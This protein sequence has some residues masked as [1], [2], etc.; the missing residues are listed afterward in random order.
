MDTRYYLNRKCIDSNL[1]YSVL[2]FITGL[3]GLLPAMARAC[4]ST[5]INESP[6][7]TA[8]HAAPANVMFVFDDS[9]SMD[10]EFMTPEDE[11]Y[12]HETP[13]DS[14]ERYYYLFPA[15]DY[16]PHTDH[17]YSDSYT[18][19]ASQRKRWKY[20]WSQYNKLYYDPRQEYHPWPGANDANTTWPKAHPFTENPNPKRSNREGARFNLA[21][22][23]LDLSGFWVR[24]NAKANTNHKYVADALR[25]KQGNNIIVTID[26][27]NSN[28]D[29]AKGYF[30]LSD[31]NDWEL[32][33][34][35]SCAHQGSYYA[36]YLKSHRSWAKWSFAIPADGDYK[37]EV[38]Y[39]CTKSWRSRN[40]TYT[41]KHA[42][43]ETDVSH[44]DNNSTKA[45]ISHNSADGQGGDWQSLGTFHFS[46]CDLSM[47]ITIYNAHYFAW[48]DSNGNGSVD[49]LEVYLVNFED[50]DGDGILDLRKYYQFDDKNGNDIV[51]C[52]SELKPVPDIPSDIKAVKR[53]ANGNST[54]MTFQEEL[55]NFANWF[56]YYRRRSLTGKAAVSMAIDKLENVNVGLYP[57]NVAHIYTENSPSKQSAVPIDTN[58][59]AILNKLYSITAY[60]TTPLRLAFQNVGKYFDADDGD[61]GGIGSAPWAS[62]ADG[63]GCQQSFSI[64]MTDGYWNGP[65]VSIGN[66]DGGDG[67]P[68]ADTYS[69][70][71]ADLA[72]YY[73][74]NDLSAA[75]PDEVPVNDCDNNTK[76]HMVTYG[77][78]FGVEGELSPSYDAY[79]ECMLDVINRSSN[80]S[81]APVWP[82]PHSC[83]NCGKKVDDLWHAAVNGRGTFMSAGNPRE[84]FDAL[85]SIVSNISG[86]S[87]SGAAVSINSEKL[88]TD[89]VLFQ[90]TYESGSWTGDLKAFTL[91]S[92]TGD[93]SGNATWS[94]KI[95]LADQDWDTG[96]RIIT[97]DG[98]SAMP[99]RYNDLT[100]TQKSYI[101]NNPD[102]VKFIRGAQVSGMRSR[103][104]VAGK[105]DKLGDLVHS[106][107]TLVNNTIFVGGND[108]MLHAFDSDNGTERFAFVPFSA[109]PKLERLTYPSYT[110]TFYVD[111]TPTVKLGTPQGNILVGGMGAGGKGYFALNITDADS[112]DSA[113]SET[114]VASMFLWEY[115]GQTNDPDLGVSMSKV[116]IVKSHSSS[117]PWVAIFGNGYNSSNGHAVLYALDLFTGDVVAKIDTGAGG[118]NG[119]STPAVVDV[120][121]DF[122]ADYVYAGDLKGNMWKFDITASD[123]SQWAS[124][125]G[126][127][128]L[129]TAEGQAITTKPDIMRHCTRHGLMVIFG[130]GKYLGLSDALTTDQETVYGIWDYGDSPDEYVGSFNAVS[131]TFTPSSYLSG[132]NV[133][134][135]EQVISDVGKFRTSTDNKAIWSVADDNSTT[136]GVVPMPDPR[137]TSTQRATV[138]WYV[139]LV[140]PGERVARDIIIRNGYAI[141][142]TIIPNDSPCSG[143]GAS[144]LYEFKACNGGSP[145]SPVFD[146]NGDTTLDEDDKV[147]GNNGGGGGGDYPTGKEFTTIVHEPVFLR[148]P[149]KDQEFKYFSTSQGTIERVREPADFLGIYY[150]IE[151]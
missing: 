90:A 48:H 106:A 49:N 61:T 141:V 60:G 100:A 6:M 79:Q 4:N 133:G 66:V 121:G 70:T 56:T 63:G 41:I 46:K 98:S 35:A 47:P 109:Y 51:D 71:L 93:I 58:R 64:L 148:L 125:F 138:G 78:A 12:F 102:V 30:S 92:L 95:K 99:F 80:A 85:N 27:D 75:L 88:T 124:A 31:I 1:K 40:V 84:L 34:G 96:R 89:T 126:V 11:G 55:Q 68:F 77:L 22:I 21:G 147:G 144:V 57:I 38:Y 65:N 10:S 146:V 28:N 135:L 44:L 15:K 101:S 111:L 86:R 129:F 82:D 29:P 32:G 128:P 113:S 91:N 104:L 72:R 39:G 132:N 116:S 103:P 151:W 134:L 150:W 145:D 9:G 105:V 17:N 83:K 33:S 8:M 23:F 37:V 117:H 87:A 62:E 24:L 143:G 74:K 20:Q 2:I 120:D 53:D 107:P 123:A 19:S 50:S 137:G 76:Q 18:I 127:H 94:S 16:S 54:V 122:V 131:K 42:G 13:P 43:G 139:N 36:N 142:I 115:P 110:H 149:D 52:A 3:L 108:G 14:K 26:N 81:S 69:D 112:I 114:N 67:P 59:T 136:P 45:K 119:L 118:C 5:D 130:T 25:I 73:Y 7:E 140:T 97:S